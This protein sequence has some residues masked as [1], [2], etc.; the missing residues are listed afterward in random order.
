MSETE[1]PF[2]QRILIG[3]AA[4]SEDAPAGADSRGGPE[5]EELEAQLR[6]METDGP[7][8][9][10]WRQVIEH[11]SAILGTRGKDLLVGVWL[12][13]ALAREERYRG[14]AVGLGIIKGIVAEHWDGMQPPVARERARV[15][16]L[17]WLVGRVAPLLEGE[18]AE[19]DWPAVLYAYD[20]LGEIDTLTS[21][22]LRKEQVGYGDL[23]RALR[24]HRDA[25]RRGLEEIAQKQARAEAE[26]KAREEQ[27]SQPA[28]APS[29]PAPAE[30]VPTPAPAAAPAQPAP[31]AV[32]ASLDLASIDQLPDTLRG[33]SAALIARS[34]A[35]PGAYL[36]SRIG[37]WW[38]I[39]QLPP[40]EGGKTG[41]MPPVEELAAVTALR[42]AGQNAEA[43][44]AL[45]E[46][47]WTAPFWLE[48]H[49]LTAEILASLGPEHAAARATV[50]GAMSLLL[51]RLPE[52]LD[53]SFNDGRPFAD[54]ATRSWI[55]QS[56]AGGGGSGSAGP[57]DGVDRA[58]SA[59]RSLVAEGKAPDAL[60]LLAELTRGEIGGRTR[61]VR[62]I[63]QAR[64]CLDVGLIGAALP[65]LDHLEAMLKAHDLEAWEPA[66]A[67][68]VA[69]LRFRAL[70]HSDA[71]RLILE[72]RR[73][74]AL[75]ETRLRLVRLDLA[76]AARLFR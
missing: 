30:A 34:I 72:D 61:L 32:P 27:A 4:V 40:N 19:G 3:A 68:Q 54:S 13:Y 58:V 66:L 22:K 75:E 44:R 2:D 53:L 25:A 42:G 18:V 59:A 26:A 17:E 73:R 16:A 38:R 20:Q 21:A 56:G 47:V 69:E 49:R 57:S 14:L 12:A 35:D 43:L 41:A 5:F 62:Q 9:V 29:S 28:A 71:P 76:T 6:R 48:G 55:E 63:A 45:N 8:A 33:L 67:V 50:A 11:A 70:T 65:L 1:T 10:N 15:G 64:F 60:E 52:L 46:L 74:T 36:L 51:T 37:S 31:A 24:P 39:R 23:L 7:A